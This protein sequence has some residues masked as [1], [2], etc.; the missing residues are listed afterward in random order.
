MSLVDLDFEKEKG[1]AVV[2]SS[3]NDAQQNLHVKGVQELY[4]RGF[5]LCVCVVVSNRLTIHA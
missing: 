4:D 2:A 3:A 1:N 5:F